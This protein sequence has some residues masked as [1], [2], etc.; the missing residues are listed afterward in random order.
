MDKLYD[1]TAAKKATN[2]SI[3]SDLL[4]KSKALKINLSATLEQALQDKLAAIKAEKWAKS[5]RQA[6]NVYNSFI[7]EHGS[8]GDE[9]RKF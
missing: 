7:E 6:I 4:R 3:N 2:L 8:F 1:R 9:Y 5:N